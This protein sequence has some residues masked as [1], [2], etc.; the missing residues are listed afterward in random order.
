MQHYE[1]KIVAKPANM[2]TSYSAMEY[3]FLFNSKVLDMHSEI[4]VLV[5][6]GVK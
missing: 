2:F 6:I 1:K 4:S 5:L 3:L